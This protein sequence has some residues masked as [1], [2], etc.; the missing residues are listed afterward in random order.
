MAR[1]ELDHEM[2][3]ARNEADEKDAV[4]EIFYFQ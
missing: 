1:P 2:H 4:W 3:E